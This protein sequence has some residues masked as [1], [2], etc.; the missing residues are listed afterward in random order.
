MH[1]IFQDSDGV[2]WLGTQDGLNSFDGRNFRVFRHDR[3]DTTTISDQF[4][5]AITEDNLGYLWVG[6]GNGLNR[7]NRRTGNVQ[8]IYQDP[9]EKNRISSHYFP[10]IKNNNGEIFIRHYIKTTIVNKNG[11]VI[12]LDT[13]FNKTAWVCFDNNGNLWA[14]KNNKKKLLKASGPLTKPAITEINNVPAEIFITSANY[15]FKADINGTLWFYPTAEKGKIFFYVPKQNLWQTLDKEIPSVVNDVMITKNGVGW[16]CTADGIYLIKGYRNE[17]KITSQFAN[18]TALPAG[19]I[20]TAFEDRQ[21]NIWVGS[22]NSGF[23]YYNP[24]FDNYNLFQTGLTSDAVT[25]ALDMGSN[26]KCA[27]TSNGLFFL[28]K[29][30]NADYSI[31]KQLFPGKRIT[32]LTKDKQNNIWAAVQNDGLYI[33]NNQ[34]HILKTYRQND[35]LLQTNGVLYLFCDSRNRVF[36]CTEKGYF[37]FSSVNKWLSFYERKKK[38]AGTGWY[39]LHAFED[40]QKN[41][42]LSKHLGVDVLDS[43]LKK[44]NQIESGTNTTP[45]NRS[46]I[47]ACTQDEKGNIWIG[48]LNVGLYK[49]DGKNLKQYTTADGLNSNVIYGLLTDD[50]GRIWA[51]TTSGINVY[52]PKENKFYQLTVKDGLPSNDYLL[53]AFFKSENGDLLAGSSKGLITVRANN[54]ALET[55]K[56][57]VR[58]SDLKINGQSVDVLGGSYTVKPGYK[59]I[60]FE[61]AVK[62]SLQ[63]RNIYYQYRLMGLDDKWTTLSADNPRITFSKLPYKKLTMEVRAAYSL[64][65][66]DAAPVR[67]FTLTIKPP[68][69]QT[70]W[71]KLLAGVAIIASIFFAVRFYNKRKN[72]K[73]QEALKLQKELQQERERISRD[74]HDNIGAY[75]SALIAGINQLQTTDV[76]QNDNIKDLNEYASNIMG[77]LRETIWVLSK[78]KLTITAFTDRFKNYATRIVKNYPGL[79]VDFT[80]S[81]EEERELTPQISLNLF[82]I[83]QEALQNGCKHSQASLINIS[84]TSKAKMNFAL[85]D[86]GVGISGTKKDDSYGLQNMKQRASEIGFTFT[87]ESASGTGTVVSLSE[88]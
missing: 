18:N 60:S 75:T 16:V 66:M 81:F 8:R 51:T 30:A 63:P 54:I 47:T 28:N 56:A 31:S 34:G 22:A 26:E 45:I 87:I 74:L 10:L 83:L 6:T 12:T 32:G 9:A 67:Q 42:W 69:T 55:K 71:F 65:D 48:T 57:E 78:E 46:L 24:V 5:L 70:L 23:A 40:K 15:Q 88:N 80:T 49:Y 72:R 82:R 41:I 2:L 11:Q 21:H 19:S 64:P 39:V 20:L 38:A 37:V 59:T 25:S 76:A 44:I 77:Y 35:S 73:Q 86:N 61:F 14:T 68:L 43:N 13:V 3:N 62:E 27:G 29:N 58:I 85:S 79:A 36:V 7:I 52:V 4:I 84:F 17:G 1:C 53:G 33:L 50:N